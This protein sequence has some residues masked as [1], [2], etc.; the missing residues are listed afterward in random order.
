MRASLSEIGNLILLQVKKPRAE[1][2]W[3]DQPCS[4]VCSCK[5][6]CEG[7]LSGKGGNLILILQK[8]KWRISDTSFSWFF[9]SDNKLRCW[10][11]ADNAKIDCDAPRQRLR[12]LCPLGYLKSWYISHSMMSS[13][14]KGSGHCLMQVWAIACK[15]GSLGEV[16]NSVFSAYAQV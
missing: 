3:I 8:G 6:S 12:G 10:S 16:N 15:R 13:H 4:E 7:L 14:L 1:G 2:C 11:R 9:E 5:G